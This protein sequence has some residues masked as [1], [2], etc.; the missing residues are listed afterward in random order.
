MLNYDKKVIDIK[1]LTYTFL[2]G[3]FDLLN[4]ELLYFDI[5]VFNCF[6]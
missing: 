6:K 4:F 2:V 1:R 3:N 5:Q